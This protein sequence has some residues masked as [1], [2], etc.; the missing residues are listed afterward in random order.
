MLAILG[1]RFQYFRD[2]DC[3]IGGHFRDTYHI[4]ERLGR[5]EGPGGE[6]Q[7]REARKEGASGRTVPTAGLR[8]LGCSMDI[9]TW[10]VGRVNQGGVTSFK[11][12]YFMAV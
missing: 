10:V 3:L 8:I 9:W 1:R 4:W 11:I 7:W 5:L 12:I 2:S 6:I